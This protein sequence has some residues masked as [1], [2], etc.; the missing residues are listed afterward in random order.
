MKRYFFLTSVLALA[1]CGGGSGGGSGIVAPTG[2]N[3]AAR[4]SNT[5]IA[6]NSSI[7]NMKSEVVV[8][9]NSSTPVVTRSATTHS[10]GVTYT[11]YRLDDVK[12]RFADISV[13]EDAYLKIGMDDNGRIDKMT[14]VMG[15]DGDGNP[16]GGD[17][18]RVSDNNARFAGPIFEYVKDKY[19]KVGNSEFEIANTDAAL[20]SELVTK[21][22]WP[23]SGE[24]VGW[25]TV[26]GK[27]KYDTG[28]GVYA[29]YRDYEADVDKEFSVS[30]ETAAAT[31]AGLQDAVKYAYGF[32]DGKWE[33]ANSKY[34]YIEY[35][36]DAEYR[37]AATDSVT[38]ETLDDIVKN[39]NSL[40]K[41]GH[42]NLVDE[43]MDIVS[44]GK[45]IGNGQS[46][47]YSDFGHFNP[48][49][50]KKFVDLGAKTGDVWS[51]AVE[52]TND[53]VEGDLAGKDYQL[54]AG[55]YA[56]KG[57]EMVNSLDVP[58][59]TG[60]ADTK[61]KGKAIGR[62]Y[63]SIQSNGLENRN[64]YLAIWGVPK[65]TYVDPNQTS[66]AYDKYSNDAGHDMANDYT[67][68]N[69]ELVVKSD[70]KQVLSMPF[71]GFY[72]VNVTKNGNTNTFEFNDT[73]N[74]MDA[75]QYRRNNSE[76]T[77][78]QA[79]K[80]G[81]YGVNT[82]SEAAGTVYYKTKQDIGTGADVGKISREWEFQAAYGMV[83]QPDNN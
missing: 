31:T 2:Y 6:S 77:P 5:A 8:A 68:T 82:A 60:E 51:K 48:V 59:P 43:T 34:K 76:G 71:D 27:L 7:T 73:G 42:W 24:G 61:F 75:S 40:S 13:P 55:G 30:A 66:G 32:A 25:T 16:I 21:W 36:D 57:T 17:L 79:F 64:T 54:F 78:T 41:L 19:A 23:T 1:A 18:N 53:N 9:S 15:E 47:Q 26:D 58:V 63:V 81:Y 52:K 3:E 49:Y 72:T 39:N 14:V 62:V 80:P 46:L 70:G 38:K 44:L 11:S 22:N 56:I 20:K 74:A 65:D 10:G 28:G 33:N 35:G 83:K 37:V 67:T 29:T 50:S 45:D 12:L 4:V 69:A